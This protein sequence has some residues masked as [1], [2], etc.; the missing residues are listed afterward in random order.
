MT[1][2]CALKRCEYNQLNS[3]KRAVP[4]V[5]DRKAMICHWEL[6]QR[7]DIIPVISEKLAHRTASAPI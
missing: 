1:S 4:T 3:K 7:E 6:I 2:L 5:T